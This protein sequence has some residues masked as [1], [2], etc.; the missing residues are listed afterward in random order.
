MKCTT[1][2]V[3][4]LL[5]IATCSASSHGEYVGQ[6]AQFKK[7]YH[8]QYHN[9]HE[10]AKRL[11]IFVE[12]MEKAK[13]LG[14]RNPHARFGVN[15]FSDM[16]AAEFKIR[17]NSEHHIAKKLASRQ[18]VADVYTPEQ[19][20]ARGAEIDWRNYGAVTY[21]KDQGQCGCCW[22]FSSTGS[23][24]GQWVIAGNAQQV[25]SEQELVSCDTT[26]QGCGGG[27]MD[28]AWEWL[29]NTQG[30]AIATEGSYPFVS[31][32]GSVPGCSSG[33]TGATISGNQD[34]P[35]SE[36]QMATWLDTNGPISIAV[37]ATSWQS[38]NGGVL[39]DCISQQLDHAVLAI[40]YMEDQNPPYWIIKNS[41]AASWGE[42][43]YIYVEM[44]SNQCLLANSPCT[45]TVGGAQ[46]WHSKKRPP[47]V[48]KTRK[49]QK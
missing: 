9:K 14:R 17:H 29:V 44:W 6:F 19:V 8:R 24:E 27:V 31:G 12:N 33:S 3:A 5:A 46:D 10:E 40:G 15:N 1:A 47:R 45:S 30:G 11:A 38:Y 7:D 28:Y 32:G 48:P 13:D 35:A 22:A 49:A 16:S 4:V 21:V 37:D 20:K 41:W 26:N 42:A 34:L 18:P 23:I 39:T 25:L 43:G 2:L 36:Q